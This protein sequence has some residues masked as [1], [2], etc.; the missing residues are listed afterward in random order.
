[1]DSRE[2]TETYRGTLKYA[3]IIAGSELALSV[4]LK[5]P[6]GKLK[7]WLDGI[8]PPPDAAFLDAVD[9]IVKASPADIARARDIKF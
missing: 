7:L 3:L 6:V 8:E 5:V 9:V 1:M 2:Q 4:R